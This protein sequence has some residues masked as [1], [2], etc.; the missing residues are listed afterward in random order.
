[1]TTNSPFSPLTETAI[2][3]VLK[4]GAIL[5]KSFRS[6]YKIT[7]KPGIQNYVTE[8]DYASE[9]IIIQEIVN[10]Y[11]HHAFL[12]EESGASE[13]LEKAEVLWIIDPLDGT[14]NF[15]H[16]IPL[17]SISVS[18]IKEK[19][20]LCGIIYQPMTNELFVA[21]AGKGSYLNDQRI[22]VSKTPLFAGGMGAT[23]FPPN[24]HE[25]PCQCIDHF[26]R[27]LKK[28]TIIRN[29]GS[30]ALNLA[31]VASGCFDAYWAISLPPWDIAAGILLV[32]EAGGRISDYQGVDYKVFSNFPVVATNSFVHEEILQYL[33]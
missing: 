11:P 1:M 28:G 23:S 6:E 5:K 25:N 32:K 14:T 12:A 33:K 18:A 2:Q 29:I 3:A 26:L 21:E 7:L 13:N 19:E 20:I 17:F 9:K 24:I 22:Y 16:K 27:I 30:S 10:R 8:C 4:A 15:A 31:Y